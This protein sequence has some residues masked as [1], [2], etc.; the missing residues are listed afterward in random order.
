[1]TDGGKT[2]VSSRDGREA[3]PVLHS[4]R[5]S[6]PRSPPPCNPTS[7]VRLFTRVNRIDKSTGRVDDI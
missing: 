3:Y 2:Q 5:F 7:D 4:F 6:F 1:M